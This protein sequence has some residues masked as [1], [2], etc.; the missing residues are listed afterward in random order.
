MA[1]RGETSVRSR[2]AGICEYSPCRSL[3]A[4]HR[5][6]PDRFLTTVFL[7]QSTAPAPLLIRAVI[8]AQGG[9][10]LSMQLKLSYLFGTRAFLQANN[11]VVQVLTENLGGRP[12][13]RILRDTFACIDADIDIVSRFVRN[14]HV[15]GRHSESPW[16][17][18]APCK[19]SVPHGLL[20]AKGTERPRRR[21]KLKRLR[22]L[23]DSLMPAIRAS[24]VCL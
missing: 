24:A 17:S 13:L 23:P 15:Y 11:V 22:R 14:S 8:K 10:R 7:F 19:V 5:E 21:V 3:A 20:L 16:V 9:G 2:A 1:S 4:R 6:Y 18:F 12:L